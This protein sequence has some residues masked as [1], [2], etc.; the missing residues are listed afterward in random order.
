MLDHVVRVMDHWLGRGA[1]GWRLDAAY[2]VPPDFWR[3]A[4]E[5]V[6]PRHPDAWFAGEVLHGD[7]AA[8]VGE[9]GLDSVTQYEL[10]KA[11]WSSLNDGNF[12]ELAWA[13]ERHNGFLKTFAPLTFTGN[14]DVTRLASRLA[15]ARHLGHALAVLFT[16]GGVPSVY[17][18]DEQGF[19]G[20]KEERAAGTTRSARRF[21]PPRT[22]SPRRPAGPP[23]APAADRAAP[24][25]SVAGPGTHRRAIPGQPGRRAGLGRS[26][27]SR[28]RA[29]HP[30]QRGRR[31][32]PFPGRDRGPGRTGV[33]V[34]GPGDPCLVPAHGWAVLG[35]R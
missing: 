19:H 11:I 13:L 18:G 12:Y 31:A 1:S 22:G 34:G 5:R 10:W 3:R 29:A 8:Y 33:V 15:D 9:S 20:V 25:P 6:R 23:A 7:Y 35:G 4:L 30:A 27:P 17:S 21:P 32:P 14:H 26:G 24:P 16:V 28:P 2:A